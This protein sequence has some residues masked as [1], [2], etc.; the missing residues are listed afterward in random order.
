M[1]KLVKPHFPGCF[2]GLSDFN[3]LETACLDLIAYKQGRRWN[4]KK[5]FRSF[6]AKMMGISHRSRD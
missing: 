4:F 2:L 5:I 6:V 1:K 3:L